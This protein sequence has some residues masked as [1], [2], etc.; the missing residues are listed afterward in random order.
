VTRTI[1]NNRKEHAQKEEG[2]GKR[3]GWASVQSG[4]FEQPTGDEVSHSSGEIKVTREEEKLQ[5]PFSLAKGTRLGAKRGKC[6][7]R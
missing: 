4:E 5:R 1:L 6:P 3:L 2:R 7:T